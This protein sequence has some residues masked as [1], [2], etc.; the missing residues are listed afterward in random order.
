M[1]ERVYLSPSTQKGNIGVGTYGTEEERMN[2]VADYTEKIL[3]QHGLTV[4]RND[5]DMSL[6][7]AVAYSNSLS[8]RIHLAIHSNAS[9]VAGTARGAEIYCLH[10]GTEEE[11]FARV[12]YQHLETITPTLGRGVKE[13]HSHFGPGVPLYELANTTA[14]SALVEVAF[15]DQAEDAVWILENIKEIGNVL[16]RGVLSYLGIAFRGRQ[17]I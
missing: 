8:P 16:A 12:V 17:D 7:E 5:R 1:A 4:F 9:P 14:T 10:Y 15:H 11:K 3:K 13:G 2:H 6:R